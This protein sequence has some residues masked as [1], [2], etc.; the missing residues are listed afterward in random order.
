[1]RYVLISVRLT[2]SE[3]QA[4]FS[5]KHTICAA[6]FHKDNTPYC[7]VLLLFI[8]FY[9]ALCVLPSLSHVY[10]NICMK[11]QQY[12]YIYIYMYICG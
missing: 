6:H 11:K 9:Y 7:P 12:I 2:N 4:F 5:R 3:F 10:R 1:M 8:L